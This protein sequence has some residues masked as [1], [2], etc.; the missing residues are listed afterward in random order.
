VISEKLKVFL[1]ENNIRDMMA[2]TVEKVMEQAT[3]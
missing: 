2:M 1:S 3:A